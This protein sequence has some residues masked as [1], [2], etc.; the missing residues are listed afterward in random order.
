MRDNLDD[1]KDDLKK[2]T[3]KGKRT[4]VI[5]W[6]MMMMRKNSEE[7]MRKMEGQLCI[8]TFRLMKKKSQIK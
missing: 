8:Q 6:M 2:R 7:N 5:S 1:E 3:I 4:S